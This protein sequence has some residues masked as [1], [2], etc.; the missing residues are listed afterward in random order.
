MMPL[1]E[2][3]CADCGDKIELLQ[4]HSKME[5]VK[6]QLRCAKC[7][8]RMQWIYPVPRLATDTAFAA[9]WGDGFGEHESEKRKHAKAKAEAVGVSTAGKTYCPSL[10]RR[11][12]RNDPGAWISH[13]D[14]KREIRKR[15]TDLNLNCEEFG[16]TARE[17][18]SDPLEGPYTPAPDVVEREVERIVESEHEGRIE[19]KKLADLAEATAEKLAGNQD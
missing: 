1:Y 14:A 9:G 11:G 10:C 15:C 16:V 12:V 18:E 13:D 8:G 7:E 2:Y 6:D 3:Q 19:P 4:T 17:P 5:E